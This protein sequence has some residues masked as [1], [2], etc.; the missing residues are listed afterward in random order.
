M[1]VFLP[2]TVVAIAVIAHVT[3]E[4]ATIASHARDLASRRV[5]DRLADS[6]GPLAFGSGA[7]LALGLVGPR[8]QRVV[9]EAVR[10][11]RGDDRA[12]AGRRA[13]RGPGRR[14]GRRAAVTALTRAEH[15][16]GPVR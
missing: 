2:W 13:R 12:G 9:D 5:L 10:G 8:A 15:A 6:T 3:G 4:P 11:A 16:R 7:L 14:A 1:L